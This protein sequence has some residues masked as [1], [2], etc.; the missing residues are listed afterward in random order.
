MRGLF[1]LFLCALSAAASAQMTGTEAF[2]EG[3]SFGNTANSAIK[4]DINA[5]KG[6]DVLKDFST[7]APQSSYWLGNMTPLSGVLSGGM[8][9]VIDCDANISSMTGA[10][11]Q[12]CEAVNYMNKLP[13][14]KPPPMVTKTD[15][16][17]TIGRAIVAD[18]QAIAGAIAGTYTGCTTKTV[19]SPAETVDQTCEE[20]STTENVKCQIGQVVRV[21]PDHLYKCL[22][23]I[24]V[25]SDQKCTYGRVV[26]VSPEY[27]YQ[28]RQNQYQIDT[29]QCNKIAGVT[30]GSSSVLNC[31]P[32]NLFS[33][34]GG[35]YG[36]VYCRDNSTFRLYWGV[37][38][39]Y[40]PQYHDV[41]VSNPY[42]SGASWATGWMYCG[43]KDRYS[44]KS[45]S[46]SGA[47]CTMTKCLQGDK[48]PDGCWSTVVARPYSYTTPTATVTWDNQCSA[49][50][51]RAL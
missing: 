28:C 5:T 6:G 32:P 40:C 24:K 15:P 4:A 1:S 34:G 45:I 16:L 9:T 10:Q 51:A 37:V 22:E 29:L 19:T 41:V 20:Y 43:S 25:L 46:C 2:D 42:P 17:Y 26:V 14:V 36:D 39:P 33:S 30:I 18:P 11:K 21:D 13:M 31:T 27:N 50:E 47:T 8:D 23:T 48:I 3:K 12:H 44:A 49:L 35:G 7:S 38:H